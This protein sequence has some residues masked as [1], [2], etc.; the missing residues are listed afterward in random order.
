MLE[1]FPSALVD[2]SLLTAVLVGVVVL[3]FLAERL[4]WPATGLVVP[5]YVGAVL[6]IRPEAAL[7]IILE[8]V[9]TYGI[10]VFVGRVLPRYLPWD[11]TF[12]RDRFFLIILASVLVR[13]IPWMS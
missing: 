6:C 7:V 1:I 13:V 11:A 8:A 9:V 10:A 3:W 12:G 2:N 4:G 5:G